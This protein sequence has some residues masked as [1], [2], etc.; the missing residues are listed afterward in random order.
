MRETTR[1]TQNYLSRAILGTA[2][3]GLNYG[4]SNSHGDP[5]IVGSHSIL[6]Y[7]HAVGI[8]KLD[9]AQAYGDSES[10]IGKYSNHNFKV[11]TKV[12]T[13]P[14]GGYDWPEWLISRIQSSKSRLGEH[15]LDS[16]LFHDTSQLIGRGKND[17]TRAIR[18][19]KEKEK[20]ILI[21][22]SLYDPTEWN[23]LRE[24]EEIEV[25]QLPYSILDRR[26][27][28]SGVIREMREMGK[29]V[30]ARSIFLQGLLLMNSSDVPTYFN[31]WLSIL[32]SFRDQ[33]VEAGLTPLSAASS[34]VLR[35]ESFDG[36]VIGF[37]STS[38]IQQLDQELKSA[39]L[40]DSIFQEL[41][42]EE[43]NLV[44]PRNWKLT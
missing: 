31:P 10:I 37:H 14:E 15:K 8:T 7:A 19:L 27:E 12:G 32:K 11:Q 26:F 17:A 2:Q 35:N 40:P 5:T 25:Y 18:A 33:C 28:N 13:F 42:L 4:V 20:K 1:P 30:Q 3:L 34:F 29:V 6:S 22:A 41:S 36:V 23:E 38:Q 16:L 9:T 43:G 44:D 21:G 39:Q 24:I